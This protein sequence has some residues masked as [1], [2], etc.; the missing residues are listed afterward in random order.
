MTTS[1]R[2]AEILLERRVDS[3]RRVRPDAG[4]TMNEA[5]FGAVL[6]YVQNP[7]SL[8][9]ILADLDTVPGGCLLAVTDCGAGRAHAQPAHFLGRY[10]P[11]RRSWTSRTLGI[12]ILAVIAVPC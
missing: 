8:D 4:S 3:T 10:H 6:D 5:F 7:E 12:A 11:R 2:F 1:Q 9:S